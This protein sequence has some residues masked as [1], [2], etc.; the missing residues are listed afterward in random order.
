[1]EIKSEALD[2]RTKDRESKSGKDR[3]IRRG[4]WKPYSYLSDGI[5]GGAVPG[6]AGEA[7]GGTGA[8]AGAG[9]SSPATEI[10][11]GRHLVLLDDFIERHVQG[12]RHVGGI[13]KGEMGSGR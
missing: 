5:R 13:A 1:M 4:R 8:G 6:A 3:D 7:S 9:S 10:P 12:A 2:S 11:G